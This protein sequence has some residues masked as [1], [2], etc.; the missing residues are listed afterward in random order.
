MMLAKEWRPED[1]MAPSAANFHPPTTAWEEDI[2]GIITEF[3]VRLSNKIKFVG[4][5]S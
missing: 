3:A 5:L 4:N 1:E 2:N